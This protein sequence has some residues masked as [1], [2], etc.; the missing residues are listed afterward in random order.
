MRGPTLPGV[1]GGTRFDM[2]DRSQRDFHVT[3]FNA[4]NNARKAYLARRKWMAERH[5]AF[6]P[7]IR[8]MEARGAREGWG[9]GEF[10]R[11]LDKILG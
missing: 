3:T 7:A 6:I 8:E 4:I 2:N 9:P 5:P 10:T 1:H 11:A